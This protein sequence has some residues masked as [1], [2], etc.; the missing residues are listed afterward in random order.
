MEK[1]L[2]VMKK[3]GETEPGGRVGNKTSDKE[4]KSK[5]ARENERGS[6]ELGDETLRPAALSFDAPS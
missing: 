6:T 3:R 5:R 2:G 1:R 4:G